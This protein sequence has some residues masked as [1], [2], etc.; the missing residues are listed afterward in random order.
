MVCPRGNKGQKRNTIP[1][2]N[3]DERGWEQEL[4]AKSA[5]SAE[6]GIG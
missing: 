6:S 4:T 1:L 2:M 5:E 3:A